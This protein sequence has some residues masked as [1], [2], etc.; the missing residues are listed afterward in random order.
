MAHVFALTDGTTTISLVASNVYLENYDLKV[1]QD[2]DKTVVDTVDILIT[3]TTGALMQTKARA[4]E[5]MIEAA[6]RYQKT[7]TGARVYVTAQL[8]SDTDAWRSELIGGRMELA[9]D[10]LAVW[11]NY[12]MRATLYLERVPYWEGPE[13]GI[14]LAN[15][16]G[17][18]DGSSATGLAIYNCNDGVG[19]SPNKRHN[20]VQIAAGVI[21]GTL[22][23]PVKVEFKQNLAGTMLISGLYMATNADSDPANLVHMIEAESRAW[24][25]TVT[26]DANCSGGDK[27]SF[28]AYTGSAQAYWNLDSAIIQKTAGR[29]FRLLLAV[30]S[31]NATA[32]QMETIQADL[33]DSTGV[34]VLYRGPEVP[35][36]AANTSGDPLVD[37]GAF[38]LP[39][40]SSAAS[41][42]RVQLWITL[43]LASGSAT[44]ALDF[45]QMTPADA[46]RPVRIVPIGILSGDVFV[47]DGIDGVSYATANGFRGPF[48]RTFTDPL[49]VWPGKLQR[50]YVLTDCDTMDFSITDK[51]LMRAWYRPRRLTV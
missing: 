7:R 30:R 23:A 47:D 27:V 42:D 32:A 22:P 25:G 51:L 10:A 21:T 24:G 43:R 8:I 34:N 38:P 45:I 44:T 16:N 41:Y 49:V 48:L 31:R 6:R 39:P 1:P 17:T 26:V 9:E 18:W 46:Y 50:I 36:N 13:T 4:I 14:P 19:S 15:G 28:S 35:F 12:K 37:L 5:S 2:D 20:Y 3:G 29:W 33:R 11:G 40:G